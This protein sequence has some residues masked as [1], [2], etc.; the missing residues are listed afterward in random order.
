MTLSLF[1]ASHITTLIILTT[2]SY[3]LSHM[4]TSDIREKMVFSLDLYDNLEHIVTT[5]RCSLK[6]RDGKDLHD[7][8]RECIDLE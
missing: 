7:A 1:T 8:L 3:F 5:N 2:Q 6:I 4:F